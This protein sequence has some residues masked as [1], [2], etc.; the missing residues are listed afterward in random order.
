MRRTR[1]AIAA[2]AALAVALT[3]CVG[4]PTS[5]G[6]V[7]GDVIDDDRNADIVYNVSSPQPG[8]D[9]DGILDGFLLAAR[10]PA[11]DYAV[12]RQF[13]APELAESWDPDA[14]VLIRTG[15]T[16]I[17]GGTR[18]DTLTYTF[19]TRAAVDLDGR[20]TE[21]RDT[22]TRTLEFAFTQV[23]GEWRISEAA[24][25]IVLSPTSF[26]NTFAQHSLYFFEPSHRYLVPDLRWF[27]SRQTTPSRV[28][29]ALLRGPA[30]WLQQG[31]VVSEFPAATTLGP[32]S[33]QVASGTGI[34]DLSDDAAATGPEQ[35][36]RMRQQLVATLGTSDV[37]MTVDGFPLSVPDT[38]GGAIVNPTVESAVLVGVPESFGFASPDGITTVPGITE[39]VL[40]TG[41]VAVA[42]GENGRTAALLAADGSVLHADDDGAVA[43][44]QRGGLVPPS[45]D[46]FGLVW[47]A[48]AGDPA[49]LTAFEPDGEP[50][51]V[52]VPSLPA[53]ST[54]V[55]LDVSR[56]GAR[57]LLAVATDLGPQLLVGGVIRREGIPL[58]L[59]V[60][61]PLPVP[62]GTL[63]DATW[64]DSRTVAVI[65]VAD[66]ETTVT[67]LEL[68]GPSA[69]L[70]PVPAG[71]AIVGGNGGR[72]GI[73]VLSS[74]GMVYQP[75]GTDGWAATGI[76]ALFL[77]TQH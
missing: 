13:L 55:S 33:V 52:A 28:V 4:I 31:V 26:S 38:T 5:G 50:H 54:L 76:E 56:D 20:Y 63:R 77:G 67:A 15:P 75:S 46:P 48:Q 22:A 58:Q 69:R 44:D 11:N 29:S 32:E 8:D 30:E 71:V 21:Q 57:V 24:D 1:L 40:E 7:A 60:F 16:S 62:S 53:G 9:Q 27:P 73:R 49:G 19:T 37:V 68:G 74:T 42:L 34:V 23:G 72:T 47:S 70:G 3:G 43:L 59:G 66:G 64:V 18:P 36:D 12:A 25:G 65:T 39:A 51:A 10:G 17:A 61:L 6:I 2:L 45:I 41:A 35:R 14:S